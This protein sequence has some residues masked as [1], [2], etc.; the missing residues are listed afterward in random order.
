MS[1]ENKNPQDEE[2]K[3]INFDDDKEPIE[4]IEKTVEDL[5][6]KI[7]ELSEENDAAEA[8]K[9]NG[10]AAKEKISETLDSTAKKVAD[11]L[12][13]L[14]EK[15]KDAATSDEMQKS[16]AYIKANAVKALDAAKTTINSLKNDPNLQAAGNKAVDSVSKFADAAK[17]KGEE[18]YGH[19]DDQTKSNIEGV[20]N[21]VSDGVKEGIKAVDEYMSRPEVQEKI[22]EVKTTAVDL[23][24]KGAE[25]VKDLIDGSKK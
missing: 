14:K 13:D 9:E 16:I 3:D 23:A 15:A 5:K 8:E 20:C 4:S 6:R 19:L 25:K 10:D 11:G 2:K 12:N 7:Q 18:M 24:Q 1:E 21:K 17:N 22:S